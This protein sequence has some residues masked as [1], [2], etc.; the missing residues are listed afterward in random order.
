MRGDYFM[1][2]RFFLIFFVLMAA[3]AVCVFSQQPSASAP[4]SAS[5][6]ALRDYV[7]LLN[8][9][10]HPD[11]VAYFE[12]VK[13]DLEKQGEARA[14]KIIDAFLSGS[15]GSGFIY[16]DSGGNLYCLTNN[17]VVAQA[18]SLSITFERQDG[19]KKKIENLKIIATDEELDLAI[20]AFPAGEKPVTQ[21]LSFL[22]RA[23]EEGEDVFSAGFP[24]LGMTP[25]WQFGRGIVSNAAAWFPKSFDDKTMMGPYIQH[26]AQIDSGNSGGPLLA[27]QQNVPTGYAVVGINTLSGLYRQAANYSIPLSTAR[28]FID[29]ALNPKPETYRAALDQRLTQFSDGLKANRAVYPHIAEYLSSA[30]VGEN[31]E[32]AMMEMFEKGSRTVR[33]AFIDKCEDSVVGAMGYAVAWT[34]ESSIRSGGSIRASIKE[35]TGSDEEYTVVFTINDNDVSS[36]WVREYGNWRIRTFGTIAAGDKSLIEKKE[37][38]RKT[39][40]KLKLNKD[41]HVE[42]GY[43]TIIDKAPAAV[44]V[45]GEFFRLMG[46]KLYAAPDFWSIGA[47]IGYR[48][49]I[50]AGQFGFMP[51]LRVG[52]DYQNDKEYEDYKERAIWGESTPPAISLMGQ[53]GIKVTSS[54]VP[55]LFLGAAF[56][57]NVFDMHTFI[58]D[59]KDP[60]KMGL[61]ITA[62]YA[63]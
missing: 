16:S 24:G 53:A 44:Y 32:Y 30:C 13:A 57:L 41:I 25:I 60:M 46:V 51:Y 14:V 61:G 12:K 5:A 39:T 22:T 48:W 40:E 26:T 21:G 18:H 19:F 58:G 43:A 38:Q 28:T 3:A 10:Y 7:G 11:I 35:I 54:F 36:K 20:L 56:Q 63:F 9:S 23:I 29:N 33:R 34:I 27:V 42:A 47:F 2:R 49:D 55:G 4:A 1:T 31:A 8:Q 37:T 6:A 62:G 50:P 17:H 52:F 45:S 59:F 15:F